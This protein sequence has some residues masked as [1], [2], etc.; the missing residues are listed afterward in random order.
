MSCGAAKV[1]RVYDAGLVSIT[2]LSMIVDA[3]VPVSNIGVSP[4][5][6]CHVRG[7]RSVCARSGAWDMRTMGGGPCVYR[8]II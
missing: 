8:E 1:V 5:Q 6:L 7:L 4:G 2:P 3:G